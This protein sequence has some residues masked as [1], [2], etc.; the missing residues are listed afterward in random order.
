M[1]NL[2]TWFADPLAQDPSIAGGKGSALARMVDSGLRVPDGFVVT[3]HAMNAMTPTDLPEL[4]APLESASNTDLD[5]ITDRQLGNDRQAA[6]Q[7]AI[8]GHATLV[9]F[10]FLLERQQSE[11]CG[12]R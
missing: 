10:E 5:A 4:L 9:M 6:A 7:A 3:S 1:T 2:V 12:Q 11:E 8:E